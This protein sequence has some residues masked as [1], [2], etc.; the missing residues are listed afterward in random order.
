MRSVV[1]RNIVVKVIRVILI[2]IFV[3]NENDIIIYTIIL[4]ASM[5]FGQLIIWFGL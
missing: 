2:F 1:L 4:S 5:A 3:K